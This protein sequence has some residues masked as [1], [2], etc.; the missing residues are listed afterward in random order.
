MQATGSSFHF[1]ENA[2]WDSC[3][4]T[5]SAL[6]DFYVLWHVI[7]LEPLLQAFLSDHAVMICV[8]LLCCVT[9][10]FFHSMCV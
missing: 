9:A 3:G 7:M 4:Q 2:S 6:L 1:E 8:V 5:W 10:L